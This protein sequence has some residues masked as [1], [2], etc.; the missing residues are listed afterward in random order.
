VPSH[1]AQHWAYSATCCVCLCASLPFCPFPS[2][3]AL[4]DPPVMRGQRYVPTGP[5]H[6]M[7][8]EWPR[9]KN[10]EP[11]GCRAKAAYFRGSLVSQAPTNLNQCNASQLARELCVLSKKP[12]EIRQHSNHSSLSPHLTTHHSR[13][14]LQETSFEPRSGHPR[15][16]CRSYP[17]LPAPRLC[18]PRVVARRREDRDHDAQEWP[19]REPAHWTPPDPV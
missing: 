4:P 11:I 15:P 7:T 13:D 2:A 8:S 17:A 10:L 3:T 12:S 1:S 9:R 19:D 16:S 18:Y 5:E 14:G 6:A